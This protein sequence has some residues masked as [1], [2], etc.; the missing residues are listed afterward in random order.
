MKTLRT[1]ITEE[2]KQ[3]KKISRDIQVKLSDISTCENDDT[4]DSESFTHI[5][6][7][8]KIFTS[9]CRCRKCTNESEAFSTTCA[10]H[11]GGCEG[12]RLSNGRSSVQALVVQARSLGFESCRLLTFLLHFLPLPCSC[13]QSRRKH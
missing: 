3:T 10:G 4:N 7:G 11:V 9:M 12:C 2:E 1:E 5:G 8:G 6:D 13:L